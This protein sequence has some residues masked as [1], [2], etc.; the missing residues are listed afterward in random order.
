MTRHPKIKLNCLECKNDFYRAPS[1]VWNK[2]NKGGGKYCS[3]SC[4]GKYLW[5]QKEY[6][7]HM[8][9]VHKGQ[10]S[11]SKGFKWSETSRLKLSLS[12]KGRPSSMGM[13]GKKLSFESRKKISTALKGKIPKNVLR[14]DFVREKNWKWIPDRT[15]LKD[16]HG[17]EERRSSKYKYWRRQVCLRDN[18]KCKIANPDCNGRLEVHHIL[19]YTEYPELRY[20]INN[21]ICL[22]KFH[23]PR[24]RKDEARLSPYFQEIIKSLN[25]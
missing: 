13:L 2:S 6:K 7:Q 11:G 1:V 21:G 24:K 8:S 22:C 16:A 20:E 14:G 17:S 4:K 23:H 3:T 12:T 19:G 5:S 15:K 10:V 9:D 25:N 18:F